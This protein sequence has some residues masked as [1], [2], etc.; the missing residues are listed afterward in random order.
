MV[1]ERVRRTGL[2]VRADVLG[3][4]GDPDG[5]CR[6]RVA[7]LA[8]DRTAAQAVCHEVE[9]LYTNGPAGGG[10]VRTDV[11]EVVG[12]VSALIPRSDVESQ[13]T[14]LE[15]HDATA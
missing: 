10:G 6:L 2:R 9:S 5:E 4:V 14:T 7:A 13:V 15:V 11:R 8:E 12:I 1:T 3:A